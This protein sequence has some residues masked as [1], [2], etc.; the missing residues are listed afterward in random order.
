MVDNLI[1]K[2]PRPHAAHRGG[3]LDRRGWF[4]S[5]QALAK[6]KAVTDENDSFVISR[7]RIT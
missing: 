5:N 3:V 7:K 6:Q 4:R 2:G 1:K